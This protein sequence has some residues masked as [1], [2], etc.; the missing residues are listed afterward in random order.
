MSIPL[1]LQTFCTIH[2]PVLI[3][4]KPHFHAKNYAE[5]S[6]LF[7]DSNLNRV[8]LAVNSCRPESFN[9]DSGI[10]ASSGSSDS[11]QVHLFKSKYRPTT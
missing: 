1:T 3:L 8:R 5:Y 4:H 10:I 11:S 2:C 9:S 7:Q 6:Y